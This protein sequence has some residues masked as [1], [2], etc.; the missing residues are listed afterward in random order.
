MNNVLTCQQNR[1]FEM[2]WRNGWEDFFIKFISSFCKMFLTLHWMWIN[3]NE[4]CVDMPTK[5]KLW[6]VLEKQL[7][8]PFLSNSYQVLISFWTTELKR[9]IDQ[10]FSVIFP[11]TMKG[12]RKF[13]DAHLGQISTTFLYLFMYLKLTEGSQTW[14]VDGLD[15]ACRSPFENPSDQGNLKGESVVAAIL[16]SRMEVSYCTSRF[17]RSQACQV[18][19]VKREMPFLREVKSCTHIVSL[20][21]RLGLTQSVRNKP[22]ALSASIECQRR[23]SPPEA[24]DERS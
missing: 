6:N 16:P 18:I 23:E 2:F 1:N 4:W 19:F 11:G 24:K 3:L 14:M 13:K 5:S 22:W 21:Q 12:H 7:R 8:R 17:F 9:S 15:L 10:G 20:C